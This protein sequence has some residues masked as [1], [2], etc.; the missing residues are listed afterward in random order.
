MVRI[1]VDSGK[2][3]E[4]AVVVLGDSDNHEAIDACAGYCCIMDLTL[5]RMPT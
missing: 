3:I 1:S 5:T 4:E 2:S